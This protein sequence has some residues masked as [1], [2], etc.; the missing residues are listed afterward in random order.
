MAHDEPPAVERVPRPAMSAVSPT[1]TVSKTRAIR[2]H[3]CRRGEQDCSL[4]GFGAGGCARGDSGG[5]RALI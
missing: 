2:R 1:I 5:R 4:H 3:D